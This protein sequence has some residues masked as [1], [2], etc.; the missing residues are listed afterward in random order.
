MSINRWMDK[1]AVVHIYNGLLFSHTKEHIWIC[2]NEVDKTRGPLYSEV[3]QEEKYKY[4]ILTYIWNLKRW[5]WWIYFQGINGETD[6]ENRS[7]DIVRG[8]E[9]EGGMYGESNI[10]IYNT[11]CKTDSQWVWPR[12][13]KQE[14]CYRL[15][16]DGR[17][18]QGCLW[19]HMCNYD[20]FMLMYSGNHH[21]I[22][23]QLSYN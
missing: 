14:L 5:L 16:G 15:K 17:E 23:M 19:G 2:S 13:L 10:E 4:S 1:G 22:L 9:G 12:E 18:V 21:N 7:M 11:M 20:W 3:S 8:E 6:L